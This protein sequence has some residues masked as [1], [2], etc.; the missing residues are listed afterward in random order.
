MM[1]RWLAILSV[2]TLQL[3]SFAQ[4]ISIRGRF[5]S[6]GSAVPYAS[7][8]LKGSSQGTSSDMNGHFMIELELP[9]N[10]VLVATGLGFVRKEISFKATSD[11]MDLG[12]IELVGISTV[13]KKSSLQVPCVKFRAAI[14][15]F[16]LR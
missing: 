8:A 6:K 16:R 14:V 13:S 4:D 9:G 5:V 12:D 11:A 3:G 1:F 2:M 15:R 10:Y 7:V